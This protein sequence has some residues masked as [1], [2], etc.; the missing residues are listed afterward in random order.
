MILLMLGNNFEKLCDVTSTIAPAVL[1]NY[2][3]INHSEVEIT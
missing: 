3:I 2:S 1:S